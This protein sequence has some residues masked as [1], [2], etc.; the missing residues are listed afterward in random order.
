M[1]NDKDDEDY[2]N[3]DNNTDNNDDFFSTTDNNEESTINTDSY[4]NNNNANINNDYDDF[5]EIKNST[6]PT[7]ID[8]NI[9]GKVIKNIKQKTKL[10]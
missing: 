4:I 10:N 8:L 9:E 2:W 1:K 3:V 7:S 6:T 5:D